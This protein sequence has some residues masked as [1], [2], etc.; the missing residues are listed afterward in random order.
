MVLQLPHEC[1]LS[2]YLL[3]GDLFGHLYPPS[4]PMLAS[5]IHTPSFPSPTSSFYLSYILAH[6]SS[7]HPNPPA[8]FGLPLWNGNGLVHYAGAL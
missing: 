7:S 8:A 1:K 4:I 6:F 5:F 3:P 2:N